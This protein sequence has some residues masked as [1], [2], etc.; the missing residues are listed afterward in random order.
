MGSKSRIVVGVGRPDASKGVL[1]WAMSEATRRAAVLEVIH[2]F[3]PQYDISPEGIPGPALDLAPYEAAAKALI[4]EAIELVPRARR[5][6]VPDV[7]RVVAGASPGAA[8]VEASADADLLVVGRHERRAL[9]RRLGSVA[10]QCVHHG[11]CPVTVVPI[12]W[13]PQ[14]VA[15]IVV[16]VDGSDT[17]KLALRWALNEAALWDAALVVAHAWNTPY[18]VEPWGMVVTPKDRRVFEQGSRD[19][20]ETMV[21]EAVRQGAPEP[22]WTSCSVEDASGP[23]LVHLAA[24]ADLLV[25]GSRGRGGFAALLLGSTSLQCLH[26]A[27]CPVTVV[28]R[29]D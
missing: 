3:H 20:I 25:V 12:E 14:P 5:P 4:D 24:D 11:R 15:R 27:S 6:D 10:H 26:H 28:P 8:L 7:Q 23:G 29:G 21:A 19:L 22:E 9:P 13:S 18:P 16:G 2:A 1:E 17:S